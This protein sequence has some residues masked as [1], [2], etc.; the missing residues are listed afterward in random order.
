MESARLIAALARG[1]RGDLGLAEDAAQEALV[2]ALEQW[3]AEG[4]PQRPGAWLLV[5][6]RRRAADAARRAQRQR[7]MH[8]DIARESGR[9]RGGDEGHEEQAKDLD[10]LLDGE[11]QD[12]VLRLIFMTCHPSLPPEAQ[13]ALTLRLLCGLSTDE[14]ARAFLTPEP[15]IAQR[16]VRAKRTLAAE[17]VAFEMP[18]G[19]DLPARL[20]SVLEVIYLLFNEGYS[21]SSGDEW[22]RPALCEEALRLGR[23]LA[24]QM[25]GDAE[26]HGLVA[27]M[28]LQASRTGARTG[29]DG[30]PILL[31]DQERWRWDRLLIRRGLAALDRARALGTAA[32]RYTLQA[33]IAACHARASEAWQTD[34]RSIAGFYAALE[35]LVGGPVV[36]LNHA[37]AVGMSE[38][39]QAG[40]D[41]LQ[42]LEDDPGMKSYHL[43]PSVRGDFLSKLGRRKD[44]REAFELAARL[45]RNARE[46]VVLQRRAEACGDR[47]D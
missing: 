40:L 35:A 8:E 47:R 20:E 36:R 10:G 13:S 41:M 26:V 14:I 24:G 33:S 19:N 38:G 1:F 27:L 37:V 46:R 42:G 45:T 4:I 5:A 3:P 7:R 34:W 12:D 2:A 28:E 17:R 31:L 15:T 22:M 23:L 32:G 16:I 11:I 30:E 29:P 9:A 25:P 39:P 6:A 18:T 43:L 21:A 44:A